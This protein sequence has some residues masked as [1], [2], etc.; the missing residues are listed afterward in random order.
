MAQPDTI[1]AILKDTDYDFSLFKEKEIDYLRDRIFV[2]PV[3]GK[4]RPFVN[5]V[6]R[7]KDIQLKP[8]EGRPSALCSKAY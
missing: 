8:E 6:A 3:R 2:K 1:Q 5:C 4:E 7:D